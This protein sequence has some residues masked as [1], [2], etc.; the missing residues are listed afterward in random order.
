[1]G[2]R[3]RPRP[4]SRRATFPSSRFSVKNGYTIRSLI[5]RGTN[6]TYHGYVRREAQIFAFA[7]RELEFGI[8]SESVLRGIRPRRARGA[9]ICMIIAKGNQS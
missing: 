7:K 8:V 9:N 5:T 1:M 3:E 2:A 4:P 6:V